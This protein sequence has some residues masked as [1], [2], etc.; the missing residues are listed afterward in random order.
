[1][2]PDHD[3]T[4]VYVPHLDYDLQR[5]GPA[6][7]QAVRAARDVDAT[8]APL[9]DE[10]ERTGATVVLLSEYGITEASHPV[11]VNRALRAMLWLDACPETLRKVSRS[12]KWPDLAVTRL[13]QSAP[14]VPL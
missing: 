7:R 6:S 9:H 4:L 14:Y 5:F 1:M 11:D 8:L 3:L 13:P 2:L 10:A 12:G